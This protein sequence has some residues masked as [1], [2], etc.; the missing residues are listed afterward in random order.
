MAS[1]LDVKGFVFRA[2][3]NEVRSRILPNVKDVAT[4]LFT[5]LIFRLACDWTLEGYVI[6]FLISLILVY[7][8]ARVAQI[9]R[10]IIGLNRMRKKM[11]GVIGAAEVAMNFLKK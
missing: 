5:T 7:I 8:V 4:A 1:G 6:F 3:W 2:I 9:L 11:G 10:V